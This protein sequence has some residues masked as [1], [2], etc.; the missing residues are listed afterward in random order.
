MV[1][2][3]DLEA[4]INALLTQLEVLQS[5]ERQEREKIKQEV[6]KEVK[7]EIIRGIIG[8]FYWTII[9]L[10][11]VL[12]TYSLLS[13]IFRKYFSLPERWQTE[14]FS[15]FGTGI[16]GLLSVLLGFWLSRKFQK[17]EK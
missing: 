4:Q 12:V 16:F 17:K 10:S 7:K 1:T 8:G 15:V 13:S 3:D 2:I 14:I 6:K 11:F 9:L 5:T